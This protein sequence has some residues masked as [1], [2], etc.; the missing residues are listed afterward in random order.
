MNLSQL[1][2]NCA[3]LNVTLDSSEFN[4]ALKQ[5]QLNIGQKYGDFASIFFASYDNQWH[6]LSQDVRETILTDYVN[7]ERK[8]LSEH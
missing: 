1:I 4:N 3:K 8:E 7:Q 6:F 5:I 2:K